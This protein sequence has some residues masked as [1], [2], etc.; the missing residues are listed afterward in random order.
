MVYRAKEHANELRDQL[1]AITAGRAWWNPT[2]E[3]DATIQPVLATAGTITATTGPLTA[4]QIQDTQL[5]WA[6]FDEDSDALNGD[7]HR[8]GED[9]VRPDDWPEG[10]DGAGE[11]VEVLRRDAD[12]PSSPDAGRNSAGADD[13]LDPACDNSTTVQPTTG[14]PTALVEPTTVVQRAPRAPARQ[15]SNPSPVNTSQQPSNPANTATSSSKPAVETSSE[16]GN[17]VAQT[18]SPASGT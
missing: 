3:V 17:T 16:G 10:Q 13:H 2:A 4:A 6:A 12:L 15:S 18:S 9:G 7:L 5:A 11:V 1:T 8:C 14:L